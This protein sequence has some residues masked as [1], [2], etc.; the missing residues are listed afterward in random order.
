MKNPARDTNSSQEEGKMNEIRYRVLR[1]AE[2]LAEVPIAE[3]AKIAAMLVHDLESA[4]AK[5]DLPTKDGADEKTAP[6][7]A[8]T[9]KRVDQ[10]NALVVATAKAFELLEIAYYG[11]SGLKHPGSYEA[12]LANFVEGKKIDEEGLAAEAKIPK[13]K[14]KNDETAPF[15]KGLKELLPKLQRADREAR[16]KAWQSDRCR[17]A[18]PEQSDQECMI[19]VRESIAEM[20]KNGIPRALF[21]QACV[22]LN[23]KWW[24]R[25]M[26]ETRSVAGGK[27]GRPKADTKGRTA[28]RRSSKTKTA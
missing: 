19:E 26:S 24:E 3:V 25:R 15:D 17:E 11:N 27:G 12:G 13:W 28:Q 16:F 7:K 6:S 4:A 23:D 21:G 18:K 20:K 14:W 2:K 5:D 1:G 22:T 9:Q 10:G 8:A